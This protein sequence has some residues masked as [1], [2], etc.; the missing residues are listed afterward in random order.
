LSSDSRS[1]RPR[2]RARRRTGLAAPERLESRDLMAASA[3][4]FSLPDLSIEGSVGTRAAWGGTLGVIA[5]VLNT[6]TSTITNPIAQ[7]PGDQTTADAPASTVAVVITPHHAL[8]HG[9]TIGTFQAPPVSQNSLEQIAEAFKLPPRPAGFQAGKFF[10]HLIVNAKGNV[11]E[12]NKHNDTTPPLKVQVAP[13]ALPELRATDLEVPAT[14]QPGDT[15][16]PSITITNFGTANSGQPIEVALVASTTPNFTVGSSIVALYSLQTNIPPASAVPPGGIVNAFSET[17]NPLNDT[18]TFTGPAVT[19]PT[20]P[21]TYFLG[22]VVDPYGKIPQLSLP[23]NP[24]AEIHT[25]GPPVNGL[26]PAGVVSTANSNAFP[27]PASGTFIGI[28]PTLTSTS[29]ANTRTNSTLN[30]NNNGTIL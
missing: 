12:S 26:P 6:G 7:A 19:L 10:V 17:E 3:L 25:V 13:V 9:I 28:N 2:R 5:T 23:A 11:L 14:L 27:F 4:G 20:S 1:M 22:V 8:S 29:S 24:L 18:F 30:N 21:A 16:E 15:I